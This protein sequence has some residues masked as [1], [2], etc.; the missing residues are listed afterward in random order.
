M[1]KRKTIK[2]ILDSFLRNKADS[3]A[4]LMVEFDSKL[5]D[6]FKKKHGKDIFKVPTND[7]EL[8]RITASL[9]IFIKG[10]TKAGFLRGKKIDKKYLPMLQVMKDKC[11]DIKKQIDDY[12]NNFLIT[13]K[14]FKDGYDGKPWQESKYSKYIAGKSRVMENKISQINSNIDAEIKF[15]STKKNVQWKKSVTYYNKEIKSLTETS[16]TLKT[17]NMSLK[18]NDESFNLAKK[19]LTA[20][21]AAKRQISIFNRESRKSIS[22]KIKTLKASLKKLAKTSKRTK[23]EIKKLKSKKKSLEKNI[24]HIQKPLL[25]LMKKQ[26]VFS[27]YTIK[28]NTETHLVE[29]T[30]KEENIPQ[31]LM[32]LARGKFK[33]KTKGKTFRQIY[34]EM[35]KPLNDWLTKNAKQHKKSTRDKKNQH[36]MDKTTKIENYQKM[37]NAQ[38]SSENQ[39]IDPAKSLAKLKNLTDHYKVQ[40][41]QKKALR[42]LSPQM[43]KQ[44]T[45]EMEVA[46]KEIKYLI[47]ECNI[48]P[49]DGN[50]SK[51]NKSPDKSPISPKEQAKKF[52]KDAQDSPDGK[53]GALYIKA[54]NL[55]H[56]KAQYQASWYTTDPK[57][58]LELLQKAANNGHAVA[59]LELG[60]AY[61]SGS[62]FADG[63][64]TTDS[65]QAA[66][67]LRMARKDLRKFQKT[68]SKDEQLSFEE[69]AGTK[70]LD[71]HYSNRITAGLKGCRVK[72]IVVKPK[73]LPKIE[74]NQHA[75]KRYDITI[76]KE[77]KP[78]KKISLKNTLKNSLAGRRD[79]MKERL[80]ALKTLNLPAKNLGKKLENA[81]EKAS[82]L[83]QL[84]KTS[85]V[86]KK[87]LTD[88][89]SSVNNNKCKVKK[90]VVAISKTRN[91]TNNNKFD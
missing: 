56:T 55:G 1:A 44:I 35:E 83:P 60:E 2:E 9:D 57:E 48:F 91:K 11:D 74:E 36:Y 46:L 20:A 32:K 23:K 34:K 70:K 85:L 80:Q 53:E 3:T 25:H 22:A 29:K 33:I 31:K 75:N 63:D 21:I 90:R 69:Y 79:A 41:K 76:N 19:R 81:F 40:T 68:L 72:K 7:E 88:K 58:S 45:K 30:S 77:N 89:K 26:N 54:A 5:C 51:A 67:Y 61:S 42:S 14:K 86:N 49:K 18:N 6:S 47:D 28:I 27:D 50:K 65:K 15:N 4:A 43:H 38:Y 13:N 64:V 24:K 10:R 78:E 87:T 12:N 8:K 84:K 52:Y 82:K 16:V 62:R 37:L 17:S 59:A 39:E 71:S 73:L 66:N